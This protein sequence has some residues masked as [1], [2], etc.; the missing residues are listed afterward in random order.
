MSMPRQLLYTPDGETLKSQYVNLIKDSG[1]SRVDR[2]ID[3]IYQ[4]PDAI[5]LPYLRDALAK[6]PSANPAKL[7]SAISNAESRI[8]K[9][10]QAAPWDEVHH[11]RASLSS[12]R[13]VRLLSPEQ[14]VFALNRLADEVGGPIGNSRFNLRGNSAGRGAHTGGSIPWKMID[15]TKYRDAYD[16][17][18]IPVEMSMHPLGTNAAKDPRGIIVPE[19]TSGPEFVDKAKDSIKIQ[20]NDTVTGRYSD[21]PRRIAV[22]NMISGAQRRRGDLTIGGGL[23]Y[24]NDSNPDDVQASKK[25][26]QLPGNEQYRI[27]MLKAS[28]HPDSPQGQAFL[29]RPKNAALADM[30]ISQLYHAG[31]PI[32]PKLMPSVKSIAGGA[33]ID[34]DTVSN[35]AKGDFASALTGASLGAL[36]ETIV[37]AATTPGPVP[38]ALGAR[39]MP[40]VAA[41]AN[42]LSKANPILATYGAAQTLKALND[43]RV[44]NIAKSQNK[45]TQQLKQEWRSKDIKDYR[46]AMNGAPQAYRAATPRPSKPA[47]LLPTVNGKPLDI[48]NELEHLGKQLY[49]GFNH[50]INSII[51]D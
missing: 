17:P 34:P 7:V 29:R 44:D 20:F 16:L 50:I 42:I 49:K 11:G 33:L 8:F 36:G 31:I 35:V 26:L 3:I 32:S 24:G 9:D 1:V 30:Y 25:F 43:V 22:E 48:P 41:G 46:R 13:N 5:I 45:T 38:S 19:M 2:A 40:A 14:R 27:N 4:T 21:L 23:L 15:G 18:R 39:L 51:R 10:F 6:N 12:M 47:S 28:F 37:K